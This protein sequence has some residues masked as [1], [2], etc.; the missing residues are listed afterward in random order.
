MYI[1]RRLTLKAKLSIRH[2]SNY[3]TEAT[4]NGPKLEFRSTKKYLQTA[5]WKKF[6]GTDPQEPPKWTQREQCVGGGELHSTKVALVLLIQQ[7][8]V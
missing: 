3:P 7:P 5:P 8:R 4:S 1:F 6:R 2:E